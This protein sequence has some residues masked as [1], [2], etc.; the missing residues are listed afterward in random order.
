L[1]NKFETIQLIFLF[2]HFHPNTSHLRVQQINSDRDPFEICRVTKTLNKLLELPK[3]KLPLVNEYDFFK[4]RKHILKYRNVSH[5]QCAQLGLRIIDLRES[6]PKL[7][8][9]ADVDPNRNLSRVPG[10]ASVKR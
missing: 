1:E 2:L 10:R 9:F 3:R 5:G 7:A 8:Q 4:T 6:A